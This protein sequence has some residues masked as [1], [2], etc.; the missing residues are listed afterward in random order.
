L[1]FYHSIK[2]KFGSG[3]ERD[4]GKI[5]NWRFGGDGGIPSGVAKGLEDE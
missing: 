1:V 4:G 3:Q 5:W 2:Y